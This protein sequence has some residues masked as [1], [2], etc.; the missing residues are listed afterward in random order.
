[1][2]T[3]TMEMELAQT[4]ART[5]DWMK[6]ADKLLWDCSERHGGCQR[7]RRKMAC[8]AEWG[9]FLNKHVYAV[10]KVDF[11]AFKKTMENIEQ[12][13]NRRS[14]DIKVLETSMGALFICINAVVMMCGLWGAVV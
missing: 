7:C 12:E 11:C 5:T 13:G 8:R 2:A 6:E 14:V 10:S 1:M 3:I 4:F 9:K